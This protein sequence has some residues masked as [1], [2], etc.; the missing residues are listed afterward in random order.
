METIARKV[1]PLRKKPHAYGPSDASGINDGILYDSTRGFL[2]QDSL[3]REMEDTISVTSQGLI[4]RNSEGLYEHHIPLLPPPIREETKNMCIC[5]HDICTT[6]LM[7]P[8]I[9]LVQCFVL[10]TNQPR[11]LQHLPHH[12]IP[13]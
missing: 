10:S 9:E 8:V 6:Q 7:F 5:E 4:I 13:V 12:G 3:V 11:H 2:E 1:I